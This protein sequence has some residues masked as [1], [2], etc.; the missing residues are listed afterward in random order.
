MRH[1][2]VD[3]CGVIPFTHGRPPPLGAERSET[4]TPAALPPAGRI[5]RLPRRKTGPPRPHPSRWPESAEAVRF[6]R[7]SRPGARPRPVGNRVV[8]TR[9]PR[10]DER[11]GLPGK[12][13]S[14]RL[15]RVH[16][17]D[18]TKGI[19]ESGVKYA[20]KNFLPLRDFRHLF[21]AN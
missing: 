9:D 3:I 11:D 14:I 4:P 21:D 6:R 1:L 19:V 18:N 13:D 17:T 20:K 12:V 7:G 5:F 2:T 16:L 15:H 10:V 8:E